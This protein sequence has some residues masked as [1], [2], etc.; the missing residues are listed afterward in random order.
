MLGPV[1]LGSVF[2][3]CFLNYGQFQFVCYRISYFCVSCV[4]FTNTNTNL[5]GAGYTEIGHR[6]RTNANKNENHA[7]K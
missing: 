1:G 4:L 6:R 7:M 5:Q 2:V 3:F